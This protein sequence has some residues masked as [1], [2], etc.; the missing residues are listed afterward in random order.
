MSGLSDKL[1]ALLS[2]IVARLA[3]FGQDTGE[4]MFRAV[5]EQLRKNY[6]NHAIKA[7]KLVRDVRLGLLQDCYHAPHSKHGRV[8]NITLTQ[9][10]HFAS[11][12]LGAIT[13]QVRISQNYS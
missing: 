7:R 10:L 1:P 13:I 11:T 5:V 4:Q 9:L 8:Q 6:H 3:S 12:F 2:L